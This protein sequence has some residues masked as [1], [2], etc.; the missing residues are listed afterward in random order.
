MGDDC[1]GKAIEVSTENLKSIIPSSML[2]FVYLLDKSIVMSRIFTS[3]VWDSVFETL[4]A[5]TN[6]YLG[7]L[8]CD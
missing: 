5:M 2:T 8:V 6:V 1:S 7:I 3:S 4:D